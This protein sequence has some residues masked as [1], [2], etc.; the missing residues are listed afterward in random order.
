VYVYSV[1]K[2]ILFHNKRHPKKMGANEVQA[3]PSHLGVEVHISASTQNQ[4]F[5]AL[6]FP[7]RHML[8][9]ELGRVDSVLAMPSHHMPTYAAR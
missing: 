2:Y 5:S 6:F 7:C 3:L 9:Q 8:N 1:K 4:A